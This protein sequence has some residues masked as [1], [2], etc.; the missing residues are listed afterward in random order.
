M[1]Y[2]EFLGS[3]SDYINE[4]SEEVSVS[5]RST[6]KN[7]G[8]KLCGLT[9]SCEGCNASPTIYMEDYYSRYLNGDDI[10]DIGDNLLQQYRQSNPAVTLDMSF[11]DDFETVKDRLYIKLI[12]REKNRDFLAEVP[13]EEFL[14]LAVVPYVRVYDRKIGNGII[15]V[16]NEHLKLWNKGKEEV[17]ATARKNT[18]DHDDFNIR[19]IADVL[20]NIAGCNLEKDLVTED[21][22]PMYVATNRKM[23]NGAAVLTMN[24]KLKGFSDVLGG[25][26]Y[27]IPSSVH[28][29]ILFAPGDRK[30]AYEIDD[31]I[32]EVNAK[33]LS[34]DEILSDHAYLYR[35]KDEVLIF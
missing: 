10:C 19:H 28:E 9:F 5:V 22:F 35:A 14:D 4:H 21:E 12:N 25:D 17:I 7:N 31:M 30:E 3:V 32:K 16:R 11:F 29:L 15:M 23:Q 18:H 8:V 1:E 26:F 33:E 13:Y 6:V 24:D 27:V 2:M 34:P 20:A